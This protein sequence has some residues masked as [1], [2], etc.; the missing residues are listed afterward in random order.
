[1]EIIERTDE[2]FRGTFEWT[3]LRSLNTGKYPINGK[4]VGNRITW[5][6]TTGIVEDG[7]IMADWDDGASQ[8]NE[9]LKRK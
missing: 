5:E 1:M 3:N 4:L 6:G 9:V 2:N 7:T 8:G